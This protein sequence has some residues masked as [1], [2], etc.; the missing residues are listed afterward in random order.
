MHEQPHLLPTFGFDFLRKISQGFLQCGSDSNP[1]RQLFAHV[2]KPLTKLVVRWDMCFLT[3]EPPTRTVNGSHWNCPN[4]PEDRAEIEA[5]RSRSGIP[6]PTFPVFERPSV[7][8][9]GCEHPDEIEGPCPEACRE[10]FA[11]VNQA[12]LQERIEAQKKSMEWNRALERPPW[13]HWA[14]ALAVV[15]ALLWGYP[16][17]VRRRVVEARLKTE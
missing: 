16:R 11:D 10:M 1:I 14:V 7:L 2:P 5:Y 8:P 6:L 9:R 3:K 13:Q 17:L 4:G 12:K 15:Q